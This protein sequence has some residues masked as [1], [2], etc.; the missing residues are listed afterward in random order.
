MNDVYTLFI[1]A[2][3]RIVQPLIDQSNRAGAGGPSG[4]YSPDG[5]MGYMMDTQASMM[6][7]RP[8]DP[9]DNETL[10]A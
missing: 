4:A 5:A 3:R 1:N 2:R 6:H 9:T 7:A 10:L 8:G